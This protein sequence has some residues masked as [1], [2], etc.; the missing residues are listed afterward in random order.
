[1]GDAQQLKIAIAAGGTAGHVNPALSLAHEL[2]ARG[3]ELVFVGQQRRLEGKLVPQAG[4]EF[5]PIEVSG[6]NRRKPWTLVSAAWRMSKAKRTIAEYFARTKAPDVAIG[7]GAYT[8]LALLNWCKKE[9]IPYLIHEQNSVPGLANKLMSEHAS[10]LTYA[11]PEA[12]EGL[13]HKAKAYQ[14]G[15]PVRPEVLDASRADGRAHFEIAADARVLLVF[16]GS[17]GAQAINSALASVKDELMSRSDL[18]IIHATGEKDY[19]R[20]RDLLHLSDAE[21]SRYKLM[22]Y[23]SDMA[24]ALAAA[25]MVVSRAGASTVAEIAARALPAVLM[26]Y[27]EATADHQSKNARLLVDAGAAKLMRD[28]EVAEAGGREKFLQ[29]LTDLLDHP[30]LRAQMAGRARA[31]GAQDAHKKLADIVI[32]TSASEEMLG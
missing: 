19:E 20:T 25:D 16:G 27:P 32:E 18:Y 17:L 8:E 1:M 2:K 6:L 7:F 26:P 11:F 21:A 10:A 28:A 29:T 3:H 15:I 4:F 30:D 14:V 24:L 13:S 23:L 31:L 22:P 12:L 5:L 9:H